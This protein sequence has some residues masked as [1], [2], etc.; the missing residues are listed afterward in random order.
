MDAATLE[1]ATEPFF[2]TKPLGQGTGL[3]LAMAR[4]F[5]E[6]SGGRLA[7]DSAPGR[8]TEVTLWLPMADR[9]GPATI[10]GARQPVAAAREPGRL[11]VVD[12]EQPVR[13]VLA[14][15]LRLA[16]YQVSEAGDGA[17]AVALLAEGQHIDVIVTDLAMPG[18]DGISLIRAAR[19][20]RPGLPAILIT[21]YA[22]DAALMTIG[23]SLGGR[24]ALLRKPVS[25]ADLADEVAVLLAAA[26]ENL[27][28]ATGN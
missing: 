13:E 20:E 9:A 14:A 7:I 1:R 19:Q 17:A 25:A 16:G 6:R 27:K 15:Q 28:G 2:T 8:G 10:G 21:G 18:M 12:D 5:A 26:K 11:L 22:G 24:F 3:G 4:S 23:N